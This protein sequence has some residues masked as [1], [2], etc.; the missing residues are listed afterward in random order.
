MA[1]GSVFRSGDVAE[2]GVE[3][4]LVVGF[5]S[6]QTRPGLGPHDAEPLHVDWRLVGA[7]STTLLSVADRAGA[8]ADKVLQ[9]VSYFGL[10][11]REPPPSV[12]SQGPCVPLS[13]LVGADHG[14]NM[15]RVPG[16]DS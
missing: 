1:T 2:E 10:I 5:Q 11:H 3:F 4:R 7:F 16:W 6:V 15:G 9:V 13:S 12:V 14:V 8:A